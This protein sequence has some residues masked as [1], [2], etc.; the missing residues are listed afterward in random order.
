MTTF[1]R[2]VSSITLAFAFTACVADSEGED[3]QPLGGEEVVCP[4]YIPD[5]PDGEAPADTNNDG[6]ALECA[7]VACPAIAV[8]CP[9]GERP[10]DTD[11]DGCALECEPV[12]CPAYVPDCGPDEVPMDLDGDGCAL[13]CSVFCGNNL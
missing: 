12:V 4:A 7:P 3:D 13:E 5:C 8:E 2:L 9:V 6:C 10:A 1:L 11:N